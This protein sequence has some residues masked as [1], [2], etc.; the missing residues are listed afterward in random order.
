MSTTAQPEGTVQPSLRDLFSGFLEIALSGFGGV[1]AWA[2]RGI[3]ER[4]RW[5]SEREFAELLGLSQ[6][7]PGGNIINMAIFI[8]LRFQGWRGV[9]VSL[10]GLMLVPFCLVLALYAL[11]NGPN[12][13]AVTGPAL[14]GAAPVVAGLTLSAG[15]KI[16][17]AHR[18]NA[19]G[20]GVG[21]V[22]LVAIVVLQL[23]LV[24]V[25]AILAPASVALAWRRV[26]T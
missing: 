21:I 23:P 9:I 19:A 1:L 8:G 4:R 26:S 20:L 16:A 17:R 12:V 6:I 25:L 13:T 14:R 5:V 2:H 15:V 10:T 22:T 24:P 3:V 18:W 11:A 7:L